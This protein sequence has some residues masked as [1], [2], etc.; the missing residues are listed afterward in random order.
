MSIYLGDKLIQFDGGSSDIVYGKA[1]GNG[2]AKFQISLKQIPKQIVLYASSNKKDIT[3]STDIVSSLFFSND[4]GSQTSV[5]VIG[6]KW[7]GAWFIKEGSNAINKITVDVT[8]IT[9][10]INFSNNVE[11]VYF[12]V[13]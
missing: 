2:T 9:A 3:S 5:Y 8:G 7:N 10:P 12:I 11:Y 1:R 13:Y 4:D 6:N